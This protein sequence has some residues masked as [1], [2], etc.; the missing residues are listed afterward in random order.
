MPIEPV[1]PE[2]IEATQDQLKEQLM[3]KSPRPISNTENAVSLGVDT[4]FVYRGRTYMMHP[5]PFR[6][7]A[8]LQKLRSAL[9]ATAA[10]M[11]DS[12][13][14]VDE[15]TDLSQKAIDIIWRL[16]VPFAPINAVLKRTHL[17]RNPMREATD[18]EVMDLVNFFLSRR[19]ISSLR[20]LSTSAT[21]H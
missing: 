17:A 12:D 11:D 18:G 20:R 13:T 1:R 21:V 10:L 3:S 7:G 6:E 2:L 14:A 9:I 8:E 19:M 5:V 4:R 16:S 15:Y